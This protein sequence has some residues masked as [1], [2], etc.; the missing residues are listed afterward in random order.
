MTYIG[1]PS[2]KSLF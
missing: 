2:A 1:G